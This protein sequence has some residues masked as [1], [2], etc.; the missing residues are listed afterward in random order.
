MLMQTDN[1]PKGFEFIGFSGTTM[2]DLETALQDTGLEVV[3][4]PVI[5]P[6]EPDDE[7]D[8]T[9]TESNEIAADNGF[10][11]LDSLLEES[12]ALQNEA[13]LA[14]AAK[15]RLKRGGQSRQEMLEDQARIAAWEA[16]HEWVAQ[17]N[18]AYFEQQLCKCGSHNLV[19][20]SLLIRETHRHMQSA[21]RWRAVT[22]EQK[23]LP[24]ETVLRDEPVGMCELCVSEHGYN[25]NQAMAWTA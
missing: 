19:F 24:K 16:A 9:S 12:V 25:I 15:A 21:Q 2:A 17:A 22:L 23:G 4:T 3:P 10:G 6:D 8:E 20:R 1:G 5:E 14:K 11:D 7:V 13:A 18:V